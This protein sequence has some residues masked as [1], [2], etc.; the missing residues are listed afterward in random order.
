VARSRVSKWDKVRK[1]PYHGTVL[2]RPVSGGAGKHAALRF[3]QNGLRAPG[4]KLPLFDDEGQRIDTDLLRFCLDSGLAE[5][6]FVGEAGPD[7]PVYRLTDKGCAALGS[8]E[9]LIAQLM[10]RS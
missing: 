2:H 5:T 9:K 4:G 8:R 10:V 3:L 1:L 6:W 7:M